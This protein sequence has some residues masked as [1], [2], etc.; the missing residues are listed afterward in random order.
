MV[1]YCV[2]KLYQKQ[3]VD[4][5]VTEQKYYQAAGQTIAVRTIA[6]SENTLK[7]ILT[8]HL[9][10]TNVTANA[11]GS[12]NSEL[13]YTAFGE[14]RNIGPSGITPTKFRYTGQLQDSYINLV[15]MGSRW[16]DP[17]LGRFLS[18]NSIV[19]AKG[20]PQGL[21]RYAYVDNNPISRNDASGHCW[22]IASGI[23]GLPSYGTTCNNIDMA[24]TIVKS[25]EATLG[26]K[27]IAGGY[28]AL[29][30][31]AHTA[32]VVGS[33]ACAS[34]PIAC[35]AGAKATVLGGTAVTAAEGACADGDG[36][37][38][39]EPVINGYSNHKGGNPHN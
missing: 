9:G 37:N 11:D 10:S 1:T 24:L 21:D 38:E 31:A 39:A 32:V 29:E 36:T 17:D 30:G 18:P 25:D 7:W 19:P 8:D 4:G 6:G 35:V 33:I 5:M 28:V 15:W 27:A 26:Q 2:S 12:W 3:V 22:G 16:Y 23:R 34:N 13:R 20:N 14:T